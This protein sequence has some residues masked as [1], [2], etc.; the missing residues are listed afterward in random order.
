[1]NAKCSAIARRWLDE[2]PLFLDT[3]TTGL[4]TNDEIAQNAI[5]DRYGTPAINTL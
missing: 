3:E 5:V 1:M 4:G 2:N